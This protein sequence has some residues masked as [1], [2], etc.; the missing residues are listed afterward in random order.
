MMVEIS[1]LDQPFVIVCSSYIHYSCII[2]EIK[3][4]KDGWCGNHLLLLYNRRD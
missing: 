1:C 2:E 3:F 4:Y